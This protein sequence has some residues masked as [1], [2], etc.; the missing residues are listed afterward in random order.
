VDKGYTTKKAGMQGE[1]QK[2]IPKGGVI[3]F[4]SRV[5]HVAEYRVGYISLKTPGKGQE[6]RGWKSGEDSDW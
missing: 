6:T 2:G 1:T 5:K 4:K 3:S